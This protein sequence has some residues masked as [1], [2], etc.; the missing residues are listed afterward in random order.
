MKRSAVLRFGV[1]LGLTLS[2]TGGWLALSADSHAQSR[3]PA[4]TPP[5][6]GAA[7]GSGS[8][9]K[10]AEAVKPAV[11]NVSTNAGTGGRP[12][13]GRNREE[14]GEEF[15]RPRRGPGPGSSSTRRASH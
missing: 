11:I 4:V 1:A 6:P 14:P 5:P 7:A 12:G 10:L 13:A 8:F 9:A 15:G 3:T 2:L